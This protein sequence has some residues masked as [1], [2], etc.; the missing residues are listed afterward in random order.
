MAGCGV[1]PFPF[2]RKYLLPARNYF[3]PKG[4]PPTR[5][6]HLYNQL[7]FYIMGTDKLILL[8]GVGGSDASAGLISMIPTLMANALG[9][10]R[11][12]PNLVAALMNGNRNQDN[13]G[14]SGCWWIWIFLLF[15]MRGG[16]FGNGFGQEGCAGIP[17]QL[18][19]ATGRELL[20]QAIQ[21]NRSAIDQVASALNCSSS[22][23]QSALCNIQGAV[24]K[25]AGQVGMSSQA[26]IN[27]VQNSGCEIGNQI[28]SC[29]CNLQSLI[30]QSTCSIQNTATQNANAIQNAITNMNYQNQL[31][32][33]NQTNSLQNTLNAGFNG[34]RESF[35]AAINALSDKVDQQTAYLT[36]QFC[37]LEKRE[38]QNKID[39][40]REEKAALQ[41]SA[42]LQQQSRY[43][44]DTVRPCPIP[45]FN[46]CNPWSFNGGFCGYGVNGFTAATNGACC[47]NPCNNSCNNN[48]CA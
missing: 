48:C 19:N 28:S 29:C 34:N 7:K 22:Q 38:M 12:D 35:T 42:L 8:D 32:N 46:T 10:Q 18:N 25:V 24:D 26:V 30:N 21:G 17:Q 16:F 43:I 33:L 13:W 37:G 44:I 23:L 47:N 36:S 20:M 14:G 39:Q 5:T 9:G 11:M 2:L 15:W 4:R 45:S 1:R 27:A 41:S 3:L 31:S 6:L 40:L